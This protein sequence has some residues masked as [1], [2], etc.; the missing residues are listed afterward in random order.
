M[1]FKMLNRVCSALCLACIVAGTI[2]AFT[3][4]WVTYESVFV[5]N[6][7]SAIGMLLFASIAS[8]V[9]SKVLVKRGK[10]STAR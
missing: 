7:W 2:L 10:P 5:W 4:I 3:M 6:A 9:A 1:T 8:L